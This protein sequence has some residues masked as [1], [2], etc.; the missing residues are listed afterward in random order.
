MNHIYHFGYKSDRY[1]Q[2]P[3]D[4]ADRNRGRPF[5]TAALRPRRAPVAAEALR[6]PIP[7]ASGSLA[8]SFVPPNFDVDYDML[9]DH[10]RSGEARSTSSPES[11]TRV[12]VPAR[13]KPEGTIDVDEVE[14]I[15]V[16]VKQ[17]DG[18]EQ[19]KYVHLMKSENGEYDLFNTDGFDLRPPIEV[20]ERYNVGFTRTVI[21]HVSSNQYHFS[22][23]SSTCQ[24][25]FRG[26]VQE[27]EHNWNGDEE[28][29]GDPL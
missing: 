17:E 1:L 14:L 9:D 23:L 3:N 24:K 29:R 21:S 10:P 12:S 15:E 26:N 5:F 7:S 6:T 8:S 25:A 13:V 28:Y 18:S 2:D 27:C 16:K 20:D 22:V 19:F 4:Y 11:E